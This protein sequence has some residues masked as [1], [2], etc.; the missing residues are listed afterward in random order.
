MLLTNAHGVFHPATSSKRA[1]SHLREHD[2]ALSGNGSETLMMTMMTMMIAMTATML[3]LIV[4]STILM[5]M[6]MQCSKTLL[7]QGF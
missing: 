5:T 7:L 3:A 2:V 4:T 6:T 1:H